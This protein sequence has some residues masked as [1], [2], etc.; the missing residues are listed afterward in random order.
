MMPDPNE[1]TANGDN[2]TQPA[3]GQPKPV[4]DQVVPDNRNGD[5]PAKPAPDATTPAEEPMIPKSRL[6]EISQK[7]AEAEARAAQLEQQM[8]IMATSQQYAAPAQP[9]A[10]PQAPEDPYAGLENDDYVQV[11]AA[12]AREQALKTDFDNRINQLSEQVFAVQ[13]PNYDQV[14]GQVNPATGQFVIS[15]HLQQAITK[16]PAMAQ[17]IRSQADPM[18]AK[19][20]SYQI[21][22]AEMDL[23]QSQTTPNPAQVQA[24]REAFVNN[25]V[26]ALTQPT[27]ASSVGGDGA[28]NDATNYGGMSDAEFA[29]EE[30]AV[31][32]GQFDKV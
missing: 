20:M 13:H 2:Q 32:S 25:S 4:Q 27:P 9:A 1:Q 15:E 14:V 18:A 3:T 10:Q 12:R 5:T 26:S 31:L 17:I 28:V 23:A 22:K 16:N 30:Q 21:A 29:A 11:E 19:A 24:D 6:D 8:A 7:A